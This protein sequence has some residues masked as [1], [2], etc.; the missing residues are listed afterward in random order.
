MV[1]EFETEDRQEF[2]TRLLYVRGEALKDIV[3]KLT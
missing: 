1:C 3:E 2:A